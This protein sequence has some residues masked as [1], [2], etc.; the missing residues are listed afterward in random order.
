MTTEAE[1]YP[2]EV[3]VFHAKEAIR[4]GQGSL[5]ATYLH[6]AANGTKL[7]AN[8]ADP[9]GEVSPRLHLDGDPAQRNDFT[10]EEFVGTPD[11]VKHAMELASEFLGTVDQLEQ[12]VQR[13]STRVMGWYLR[14]LSEVLRLT[15][16]TLSN[17]GHSE[18]R[19]RFSRRRRG[20]PHRQMQSVK[21]HVTTTLG[22]AKAAGKNLKR[23]VW[24]LGQQHGIGRATIYRMM[25]QPASRSRKKR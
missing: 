25:Q 20:R 10:E 7:I 8:L 5:L 11:D 1:P 16:D 19:L 9:P 6:D 12:A 15:A 17:D 18:W 21:R 22:R 2:W 3:D 14:D 13:G 24:E 4:N 23:P